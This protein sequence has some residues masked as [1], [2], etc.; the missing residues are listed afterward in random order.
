MVVGCGI[1]GGM[2]YPQ[3]GGLAAER[4]DFREGLRLQAAE[5]LAQGEASALIVKHLWVS[6][7]PVQRW[8]R[9]GTRAVQGLCG[10]KDSASP[11]RLTW[12]K[13]WPHTA[14]KTSG[15]HWRG[16]RR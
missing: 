9:H 15:G 11:P 10:R 5:R 3:E 14:G 12:P 6:V 8:R 4:H 2:R 16:S 1:T 7:R 13:G